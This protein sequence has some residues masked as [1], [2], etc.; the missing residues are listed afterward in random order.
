M[1]GGG[2]VTKYVLEEAVTV[3]LCAGDPVK[4]KLC[5]AGGHWRNKILEPAGRDGIRAQENL[6]FIERSSASVSIP[7]RRRKDRARGRDASHRCT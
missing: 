4:G 7:R 1:R 6:V 2:P 3:R 5:G